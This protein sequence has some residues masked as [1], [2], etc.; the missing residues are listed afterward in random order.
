MTNTCTDD[1]PTI[2]AR[3]LDDPELRYADGEAI[4]AHA[5]ACL[6]AATTAF[7]GSGYHAASLREI[8]ATVGVSTSALGHHFASKE[9]LLIAVLGRRDDVTAAAVRD[10]EGRPALDG[11]RLIVDGVAARSEAEAGLIELYVT[12]STEAIAADHP[13]HGYFAERYR[14]VIAETTELFAQAQREGALPAHLDPA[15]EAVWWVALWDGLQVQ[16][17]YEPE[18][19]DIR[20]LLLGHVDSLRSLG[21]AG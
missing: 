10:V 2:F 19:I 5:Q 14:A 7:A 17:L 16:W 12:L 11:L 1:L 18:A 4:L 6:E 9:D 13:A 21:S 3:L 15:F 20:G 8:A